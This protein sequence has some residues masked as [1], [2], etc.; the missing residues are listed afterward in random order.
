LDD[1]TL[2]VDNM[3]YPDSESAICITPVYIYISNLHYTCIYL[4]QQSALHLYI[5]MYHYI[6]V[7]FL[8]ILRAVDSAFS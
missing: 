7:M 2:K 1:Y 8:L 4:Y 3:A 5:F 6:H